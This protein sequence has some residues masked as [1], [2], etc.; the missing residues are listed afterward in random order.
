MSRT[1]DPGKRRLILRTALQVFGAKGYSSTTIKDIAE[2]AGIATGTVYTYFSDKDEL[3]R[4]SFEE[5]W[6]EFHTGMEH[7]LASESD[8]ELS[9]TRIIDFGFDLLVD[10]YPLVR[11][12]YTQ[13]NLQDMISPHLERLSLVLEKYF[14]AHSSMQLFSIDDDPELQRFF[15][16]LVIAGILSTVSQTP[17]EDIAK[18]VSE[19][20]LNLMRGL[21]RGL[22][23]QV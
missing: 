9:V 4:S 20:K 11:G 2:S 19:V 17:P 14:A 22:R 18:V 13:A 10:L 6:S 16:K 8:V 21:R 5:S 15:L 23:N 12:M 1:R 7:I 3:F